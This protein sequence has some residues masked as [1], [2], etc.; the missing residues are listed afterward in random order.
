MQ[1]KQNSAYSVVCSNGR[2]ARLNWP[3]WIA[4]TIPAQGPWPAPSGAR[5]GMHNKVVLATQIDAG[6][7][8]DRLR[9]LIAEPQMA[10]DD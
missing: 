5:F 1:L 2:F 4:A 10:G 9:F 8:S 6:L 7:Q 3:G